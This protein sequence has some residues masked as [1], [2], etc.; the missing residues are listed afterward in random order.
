VVD[1]TDKIKDMRSKMA[2]QKYETAE[3]YANSIT[4][5]LGAVASIVGLA[6]LVAFATARNSIWDMAAVAVFGASLIILYTASTLYHSASE[7]KL[8]DAL[9]VLDHASIFLLIAGTYTP[10]AAI[11]L[12]DSVGVTILILIWSLA[13]AGVVFKLFLT[14]KYEKVSVALY[15]AM[16]WLVV[17]F[18]KSALAEL[19][20]GAVVLIAA[21]G[22]SYTAGVIFYLWEKLPFSH[23]IWHLFVLGGS[24]LHYFAILLY[25]VM[26]PAT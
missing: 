9:K 18:G 26:V 22:L 10:I 21:G 13:I 15:L 14:G 19:S 11:A 2:A 23:A 16:G 20:T 4:H 24:V 1:S 5:G 6:V 17:F 25:V 8:R 7:G 3:Y 12:I